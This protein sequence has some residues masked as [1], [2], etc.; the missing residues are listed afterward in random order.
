MLRCGAVR[1]SARC[2]IGIF[3]CWLRLWFHYITNGTC[4]PWIILTYIS[5]ELPAAFDSIRFWSKHVFAHA[6]CLLI[7]F[8]LIL[9]F[10]INFMFMYMNTHDKWTKQKDAD[11]IDRTCKDSRTCAAVYTSR[12]S[13]F[14]W[15]H[16]V[17]IS[18]TFP[19]HIIASLFHFKKFERDYWIK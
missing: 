11:K 6:I 10:L 19:S 2:K 17:H 14:Y 8:Y 4:L 5:F 13:Y 15:I 16:R 9:N 12:G 18:A 7:F 1:W 3:R